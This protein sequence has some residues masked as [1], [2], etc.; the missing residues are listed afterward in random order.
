MK[1]KDSWLK[2]IPG[3]TSRRTYQGGPLP[4]SDKNI[5]LTQ[6]KEINEAGSVKFILLEDAGEFFNGLKKS[7][8]MFKNVHSAVVLAGKKA[9]PSIKTWVGYYGEFLVLEA[10]ASNIG[11]CWIGGT[12]DRNRLFERIGLAPDEELFLVLS[13]GK[14][15]EE[16]TLKEKLLSQL[17]KN[18]PQWQELLTS[19]LP[20]ASWIE[21]GLEA[22]RYAPSAVNKKP[23]RYEVTPKGVRAYPITKK[24]GFEETDLG[25][26]MAHFQLGAQ[27][28]GITGSWEPDTDGFLFRTL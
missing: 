23:A 10:A 16:K 22:A 3:R 27:S 17:G 15:H 21:A 24:Y 14:T 5:I 4:K 20:V 13:I 26:S 2:A 28:M 12:Y 18:K 8:G 9:D 6:I 25:I 11:T 19:P 7:Y 1:L